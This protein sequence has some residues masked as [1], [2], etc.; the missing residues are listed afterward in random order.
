MIVRTGQYSGQKFKIKSCNMELYS[1]PKV[2]KKRPTTYWYRKLILD[3]N[4]ELS[5]LNDGTDIYIKNIFSIIY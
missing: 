3:I 2:G 1:L 5:E 4:T